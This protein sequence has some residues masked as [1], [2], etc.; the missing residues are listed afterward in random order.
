MPCRTPKPH[1][2][3]AEKL[4]RTDLRRGKKRRSL[5]LEPPGKARDEDLLSL[6]A[7]HDA[8]IKTGLDREKPEPE[9][10]SV[11]LK[12]WISYVREY[13]QAREQSGENEGKIGLGRIQT[14]YNV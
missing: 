11:R 12:D 4:A 8:I 14:Q 9:P 5:S 13:V 10:L 6:Q 3:T 7:G 1:K 2:T